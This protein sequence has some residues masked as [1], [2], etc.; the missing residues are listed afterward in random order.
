M[1]KWIGGKPDHP[2]SDLKEARRLLAELPANDAFKALEEITGWIESVMQAEGFRLDQRVAVVKLLD[3]TAQQFQ[4][5]LARDYLTAPRLQKFQENRLWTSIFNFWKQLGRAYDQSILDYHAGAKGS[6]DVKASLPVLTCRGLR[7]CSAQ[8]KWMQMR[9][10]P[11]DASIWSCVGKLYELAEAKGYARQPATLYP[12]IPGDFTPEQEF[13]KIM[14]LWVSAPDGLIPLHLEIAERVTAHF[15]GSF[16][17][18]KPPR[19]QGTHWFDLAG[20]R[21]PSRLTPAPEAVG[22]TR[23]FGAGKALDE[24]G[25]LTQ[26]VEKGVVPESVNLGAAYKP[27]IV[28]DVLKHLALNWSPQPPMR[29]SERHRV[30]ARLSVV[31]GFERV[32]EQL[33]EDSLAFGDATESWIVENI[34]AGGFGAVVPQIKGDWIR[35]GCIVGVKPEGINSWGVGIVRRLSRHEQSQGRVGVQTLA[36]NA[37]VVRLKPHDSKWVSSAPG[38]EEDYR[39]AL[40]LANFP[41]TGEAL[42]LLKPGSFSTQQSFDMVA[43]SNKHLLLPMNL[44]E[45][46]E[47]FDLARF[48]EM[49]QEAGEEE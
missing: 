32:A 11:I 33:S 40:L 15:S 36:K 22:S 39:T 13:L 27:G 30:K 16:F 21:A 43:G 38:E 45:K 12:G 44:V 7:A 48:R 25:Q 49:R 1:L 29:K 2:M 9:Y 35:V 28:R 5:K 20:D 23:F 47:D 8:L 10:G 6:G 34:S 24:L 18:E 26:Q 17:I 14:I 41:E 19:K 42:V 4:R 31:S 3:E 46:G 37:R